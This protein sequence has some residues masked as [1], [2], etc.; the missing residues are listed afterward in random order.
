MERDRA[1]AKSGKFSIRSVRK[2]SEMAR[3][4][5]PKSFRTQHS[6]YSSRDYK[7]RDRKNHVVHITRAYPTSP[8]YYAAS[9]TSFFS[10]GIFPLPRWERTIS[11]SCRLLSTCLF[12]L[13]TKIPRSNHPGS[14]KARHLTSLP[15]FI[16]SKEEMGIEAKGKFPM[17]QSFRFSRDISFPFLS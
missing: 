15:I 2:R 3:V 11:E 6:I 12:R 16:S 5:E 17:A 10:N 13:D 8:E 9:P 14:L 4:T 7:N 1:R